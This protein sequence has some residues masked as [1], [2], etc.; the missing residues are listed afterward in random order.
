M[1][2]LKS[3]FLQS[4]LTSSAGMGRAHLQHL[5]P[6]RSCITRDNHEPP[7][8]GA[9]LVVLFAISVSVAHRGLQQEPDLPLLCPFHDKSFHKALTLELAKVDQ[10]YYKPN[11]TAGKNNEELAK[12]HRSLLWQRQKLKPGILGPSFKL[13]HP[14]QSI[15]LTFLMLFSPLRH[16]SATSSI[17]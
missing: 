7:D 15:H 6:T 17:K 3:R 16:D 12:V 8:A 1:C 2:K 13:R 9:H 11:G 5:C 10:K 4:Q 14:L